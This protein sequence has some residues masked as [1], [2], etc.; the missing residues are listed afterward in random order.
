M[1][2]NKRNNNNNRNG[3]GSSYKGKSSGK[4][5][6]SNSKAFKD[7]R[8]RAGRDARDVSNPKIHC[9]GDTLTN[10][11]SWYEPFPGSTDLVARV[12][13]GTPLGYTWQIDGTP[14]TQAISGVDAVAFPGIMRMEYIP[15]PGISKPGDPNSPINFLSH[16]YYT[17]VRYAQ[18]GSGTYDDADL[19]LGVLGISSLYEF[20]AWMRRLYGVLNMYSVSNKYLAE[21]LFTSMRCDF[22][23][24]Q[25]NIY[26]FQAYIN[27]FALRLGQFCLPADFHVVD[28]RV[29]MNSNIYVDSTSAKAQMYYFDPAGFW[30]Y[31][32]FADEQYSALELAFFNAPDGKAKFTDIVKFGDELYLALRGSQSLMNM[33]GDVKKAYGEENLKKIITTAPDYLAPILYD[34]E[35]CMEIQNA[36]MVGS[37]NEPQ[38]IKAVT[39]TNMIEYWPKIESDVGAKPTLAEYL[40]NFRKDAPT[41]NDVMRA[42]R[43]IAFTETV[44]NPASPDSYDLYVRECGTEY[45]TD[46]QIFYYTR[47]TDGSVNTQSWDFIESHLSANSLDYR[48]ATIAEKFDYHPYLYFHGTNGDIITIGG[49]VDNVT[50]VSLKTV[51]KL[52]LY[53]IMGLIKTRAMNTFMTK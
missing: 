34:E 11:P 7:S 45:L 49:D 39:S 10:D 8:D 37:I 16:A 46:A 3:N 21:A 42:T 13:F 51:E 30:K 35:M 26:D 28:R 50:T 2:G 41:S 22:E 52:N 25:A 17:T 12:S 36:T 27:N 14:I 5:T 24:F 31:N 23:D 48:L 40:F 44:L 47:S 15:C 53:A 32:E 43:L 4:D 18:S 9:A 20:W 1:N 33:A 29:R 19:M 38:T 6:R